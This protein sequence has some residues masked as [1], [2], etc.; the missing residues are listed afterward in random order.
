MLA[1]AAAAGQE[2]FADEQKARHE[3]AQ[4][5]ADYQTA[6]SARLA[7]W[8]TT[9]AERQ[10]RFRLQ[11]LE[12]FGIDLI[13]A[14]IGAGVTPDQFARLEEDGLERLV[15]SIPTIWALTE[16]RRVR[17]QNPQQ[18]FAPHDLNDLRA[19]STSLVYCDIVVPDAAWWSDITK[20]DL[21]KQF[22]TV[23]VRRIADVE[24]AVASWQRP[25]GTAR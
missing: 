5:F 2:Q 7:D 13:P 22:S 20:A 6:A 23:V 17:F 11:A 14:L 4:Q 16:L 10:L 9:P 3:R 25:A 19:L 18:G 21:G 1:L 12:D 8:R 15:K 24:D